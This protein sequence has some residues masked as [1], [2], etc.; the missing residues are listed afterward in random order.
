MKPSSWLIAAMM[1][2]PVAL[3]GCL[4]S[5]SSS[6]DGDGDGSGDTATLSGTMKDSDTSGGSTLTAG[7]LAD[8]AGDPPLNSVKVLAIA[9]DGTTKEAEVNGDGSFELALDD[10]K[11]YTLLVINTDLDRGEYGAVLAKLD[12]PSTSNLEKVSLDGDAELGDIGVDTEAGSADPSGAPDSAQ[13]EEDDGEFE[14]NEEGGIEAANADSGGDTQVALSDFM[15]KGNRWRAT[16]LGFGSDNFYVFTHAQSRLIEAG[17]PDADGTPQSGPGLTFTQVG[18]G[19]NGN[20][21]QWKP[22]TAPTPNQ[23][24]AFSAS[25]LDSPGDTSTAPNKVMQT[26]K[27][28]V[29]FDEAN[30]QVWL[31]FGG[32][33]AD[34]MA[35]MPANV[36][37]GESYSF[38]D[39]ESGNE[40]SITI[41]DLHTLEA[42]GAEIDLLAVEPPGGGDDGGGDGGGG[43]TTSANGPP[44]TVYF[45]RYY[46]LLEGIGLQPKH[47]KDGADPSAKDILAQKV[48]FGRYND[49]NSLAEHGFSEALYTE[50]A[51][52]KTALPDNLATPGGKSAGTVRSDWFSYLQD[53]Q[54]TLLKK[55]SFNPGNP[56][57]G[58]QNYTAVYFNQQNA[59]TPSPYDAQNDQPI[60]LAMGGSYNFEVQFSPSSNINGTLDGVTFYLAKDGQRLNLG[61]NSPKDETSEWF[62]LSDVTNALKNGGTV[63]FAL[64]VPASVGDPTEWP[65]QI[66]YDPT[67]ESPIPGD[68]PCDLV[69]SDGYDVDSAFMK[70]MMRYT[71]TPQGGGSQK[72]RKIVVAEYA[73]MNTPSFS[74]L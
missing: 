54:Q 43:A 24:Y 3:T 52:A 35:A 20:F 66:F 68:P 62:D 70:L 14:T 9:D 21:A 45:M 6:G 39:E 73:A 26:F 47:F 38:T 69:V 60:G 27:R 1:T 67:D 56:N 19:A 50:H 63:R 28:E 48:R 74:D 17:P 59:V 30:D 25:N 31:K 41:A 51:S 44:E 72:T 42:G 53:Y 10:G 55:Y 15:G 65:D 16:K 71:Y 8:Y 23:Y 40:E 5:S 36:Q 13:I 37:V 46:G 49:D 12:D 61:S 2:A 29:F 18:V 7:T 64:T 4:D 11:D 22:N 32:Q 34:W 58:S 57:Q 33:E